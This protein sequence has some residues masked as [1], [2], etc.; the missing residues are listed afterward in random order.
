M[1]PGPRALI[2]E[3][4]AR[5]PVVVDLARA[6]SPAVQIEPQLLR[7][8]RLELVPA[9]TAATEADLWFS[10]LVARRSPAGIALD[11]GVRREL[12]RDLVRE[13]MLLDRACRVIAEVHVKEVPVVLAEERLVALG[14]RVEAEEHLG[15]AV[16]VPVLGFGTGADANSLIEEELRAL[17]VA[18]RRATGSGFA[19][20]VVRALPALPPS[21]GRTPTAWTLALGASMRLGGRRVLQGVPPKGVTPEAV[22][23]LLPKDGPRTEVGV[24]LLTG[25]LEFTTTGIPP[26][27]QI[28]ELPRTDPLILTVSYPDGLEM[29]SRRVLLPASGVATVPVISDG[30][31][32]IT[33]ALGQRYT[34]EPE[35]STRRGP[36]I[37]ITR[38]GRSGRRLEE[39]VTDAA[40]EADVGT[41]TREPDV[42]PGEWS[43]AQYQLLSSCDVAIILITRDTLASEWTR[44]TIAI[45]MWRSLLQADFLLLPVLARDL[46]SDEVA[47]SPLAETGLTDIQSLSE[48]GPE[49]TVGQVREALREFA[50][51]WHAPAAPAPAPS[52]T[53]AWAA[54]LDC[55][56]VV[57]AGSAFTVAVGISPE[58]G[59]D[60][61]VLV[62]NP[63]EVEIRI[64]MAAGGTVLQDIRTERSVTALAEDPWRTSFTAPLDAGQSVVVRATFRSR[65]VPLATMDRLIRVI[66]MASTDR[67]PEYQDATGQRRLVVL[68]RLAL[69]EAIRRLMD[70][71]SQERI[72]VVN[73]PRRSGKTFTFQIIAQSAKETGAFQPVYVD[74][75]NF[76]RPGPVDL[77]RELVL[78]MGRSVDTIPQ[79]RDPTASYLREL[80]NWLVGQS[81]AAN[82]DWWWVLDSLSLSAVLQETHDFILAIAASVEHT[83]LRLVLLDFNGTLP[84]NLNSFVRREE[85]KPIGEPEIREFL[86]DLL[87]QQGNR[88]DPAEI[89]A[90]TQSVLEGLPADTSRLGA[91]SARVSSLVPRLVSSREARA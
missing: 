43:T 59:K 16:A 75:A 11:P 47:S 7:R 4:A 15:Q 38:T 66:E 27:A 61:P 5:D 53:P 50:S 71:G 40:R 21:A 25:A 9:A 48:A 14:L 8:A 29:R 65:G 76:L 54:D 91:L 22:A 56:V 3:I 32:A 41:I 18:M 49:R 83:T 87:R 81:R 30:L 46:T 45:L 78:R 13:P 1:R 42:F 64:D 86:S 62:G 6:V 73:G 36:E 51:R 84:P 35:R 68:D 55:P 69:R 31:V 20:W 77:A 23:W 70:P 60:R 10:A 24:R 85:L 80:V 82:A 39:L 89:D 26:S 79:P 57:A 12:R 58:S 44:R 63:E 72:L 19:R 28:I 88:P 34:I 37:Y 52:A 74:L 33:T 90:L 67:P 17:A 2:A